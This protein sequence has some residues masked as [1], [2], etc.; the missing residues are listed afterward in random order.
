[1]YNNVVGNTVGPSCYHQ[2]S[3]EILHVHK[4]LAQIYAYMWN[5]INGSSFGVGDQRRQF[6]TFRFQITHLFSTTEVN[7]SHIYSANRILSVVN[8]TKWESS[9]K[10]LSLPVVQYSTLPLIFGNN[11]L[12]HQL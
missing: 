4:T 2:I 8:Q 6:V 9:R 7:S 12:N 1:M 3:K 11:L 10:I 5:C